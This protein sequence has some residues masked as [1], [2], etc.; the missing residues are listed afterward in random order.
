MIE[1]TSMRASVDFPEPEAPTIASNSPGSSS[2]EMPLRITFFVRRR[3]IQNAL[4]G[5]ATLGPWAAAAVPS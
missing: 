1:P 2:K 3:H 4:D 5:E